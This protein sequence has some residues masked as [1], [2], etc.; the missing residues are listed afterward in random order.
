M[1]LKEIKASVDDS[2]NMARNGKGS[3]GWDEIM[4]SITYPLPGGT[5]LFITV[6]FDENELLKGYHGIVWA[7]RHL[8]QAEVICN[9]LA[10]QQIS[11][12]TLSMEV[13]GGSLILIRVA[14]SKHVEEVLNYIWKS[15]SGLRLKPDWDYPAGEPNKS[16]NQWLDGR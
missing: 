11:A 12:E 4:N 14:N 5:S 13:D 16:F 7:T 6:S 15:D 9:A 1:I 3:P 10:A 8:L 2:G